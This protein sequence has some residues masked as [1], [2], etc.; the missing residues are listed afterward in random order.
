[1]GHVY[2]DARVF[3]RRSMRVHFLVDTGPAYTIVPPAV[4][5]KVAANLLPARFRVTLADGSRRRL[6]ACTMGIELYGRT[7]PM[8]APVLQSRPPV[9]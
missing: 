6:K 9:A 1:M 3:A 7:A 5:Q 4:A 2:A 8:T